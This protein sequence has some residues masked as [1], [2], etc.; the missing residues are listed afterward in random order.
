MF[1]Y[2]VSLFVYYNKLWRE[3]TFVRMSQLKLRKPK[4]FL[5]IRQLCV[6]QL[7]F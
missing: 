7:R 3:F 5:T 4:D 2:V 6:T 1:P